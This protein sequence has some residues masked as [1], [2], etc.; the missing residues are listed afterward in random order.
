MRSMIRDSSHDGGRS[1]CRWAAAAL[2]GI[3]TVLLAACGGGSGGANEPTQ[4]TSSP[5]PL[6]AAPADA[7]KTAAATTTAGYTVA[8]ANP[9][10]GVSVATVG[11]RAPCPDRVQQG[12]QCSAFRMH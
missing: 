7:R 11:L 1:A 8:W 5:Q 10:G 3:T 12:P 9:P 6:A 4:L 2:A